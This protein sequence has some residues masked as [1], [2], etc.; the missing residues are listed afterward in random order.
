MYMENSSNLNNDL[1]DPE[2]GQQLFHPKIGRGPRGRS[3]SR[4]IREVG[5][6]LYRRAVQ[7]RDKKKQ[8]QNEHL[9]NIKKN[10]QQNFSKAKTNKMMDKKKQMNFGKIFEKLDSDH[11]GQISAF[12]ID[13]SSIDASLL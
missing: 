6:D 8:M 3:G 11:D 10:M 12:R 5:G 7:S 9:E 1:Y 13:I 4:S 2:T